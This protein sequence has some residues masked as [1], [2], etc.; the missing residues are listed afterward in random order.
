MHM[1]KILTIE[2]DPFLRNNI[3]ELLA[4]EGYEIDSAEDGEQG[5]EKAKKILPDLIISD[6]MM[7]NM[8]GFKVLEELRRNLSTAAI[9]LIFITARIEMGN[10]KRGM[11]LGADYYLFKPFDVSDLLYAVQT[12]LGKRNE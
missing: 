5:L 4:N 10:Y 9:P 11:K 8:D 3:C 2:D 7:P 1:N 6:I 12:S